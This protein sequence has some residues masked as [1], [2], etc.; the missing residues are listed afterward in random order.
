MSGNTDDDILRDKDRVMWIPMFTVGGVP[1]YWSMIFG[2]FEYWA[3]DGSIRI[4]RF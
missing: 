3:E 4:Y 2:C 1:I